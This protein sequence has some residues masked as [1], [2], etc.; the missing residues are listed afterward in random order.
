MDKLK[1][2][3]KY[4][5]QKVKQEITL[6]RKGKTT[7]D[8]RLLLQKSIMYRQARIT[9]IKNVLE[10]RTKEDL[11]L[12]KKIASRFN[13]SEKSFQSRSTKSSSAG[14][15]FKKDEYWSK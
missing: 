5:E 6:S 7:E 4:L 9:Q 13:N 1:E 15:N 14:W 11:L 2:E 8:E 12:E 3:L 10:G